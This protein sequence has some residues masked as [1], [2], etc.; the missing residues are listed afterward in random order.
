[1]ANSMEHVH[2]GFGCIRPYLHGPTGLPDF[3]E[4]VF[5]AAVLE[6]NE[7]GP[8]LLQIG[9][10]LVWVEA[11]ELPAHVE[12][13]VGSVY[14]YVADVDAVHARAV[15]HGAKSISAP[16][17]KPYNERQAGFTDTAGNTWWVSTYLGKQS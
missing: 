11:G 4:K 1:M 16:E 5:G 12:P 6:R 13:W 15:A 8:T 9:D 7:D 14:A 17:D 2:R 3:L 10:S